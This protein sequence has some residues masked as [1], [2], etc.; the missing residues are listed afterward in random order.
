[1]QQ[2]SGLI[3]PHT[4]LTHCGEQIAA[5]VHACLDGPKNQILALGVFHP[6]TENLVNAR[7]KELNREDIRSE[8]SR[9]VLGPDS[10]FVKHEFS[11]MWF[12]FLMKEECKR[13]RIETPPVIERYPSLFNRDPSSLPGIEDLQKLAEESFIVASDDLIHHGVAY[14]VEAENLFEMDKQ[15]LNFA[16]N[17]IENRL[18][19]LC[20]GAYEDY[21]MSCMNPNAIGD[22]PDA[23]CVLR[24]LL[25]PIKSKII[26]LKLVDVSSLFQNNPKPSWVA[27]TVVEFKKT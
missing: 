9:G 2:P 23:T 1:M 20:K 12:K 22:P 6:M 17:E 11:L 26:D 24:H 21:Y 18:T 5:C 15:G 10:H 19:L 4:F 7:S 3:F 27:T 8:S 16:K 13:R 25:G 14:G